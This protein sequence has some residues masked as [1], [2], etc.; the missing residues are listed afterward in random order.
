MGQ[1]CCKERLFQLDSPINFIERFSSTDSELWNTKS[2]SK[3]ELRQC[4]TSETPLTSAKHMGRRKQ[5]TNASP[6]QG[7]GGRASNW[8]GLHQE[9]P[10]G[11][12]K[13]SSQRKNI[14]QANVGRTSRKRNQANSWGIWRMN[15]RGRNVNAWR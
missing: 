9:R 7:S 14:S 11:Y 12:C 6:A 2:I 15:E 5:I 10:Q 1:P 13:S 3:D 8:G 4:Y